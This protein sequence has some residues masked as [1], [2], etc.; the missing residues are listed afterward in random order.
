[1]KIIN[2]ETY[3]AYREEL[4]QKQ[5]N[6]RSSKKKTNQSRKSRSNNRQKKPRSSSIDDNKDSELEK[7]IELPIKEVDEYEEEIRSVNNR[8]N[9]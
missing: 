1:L 4:A 5:A 9:D 2:I 7:D 3:T 8:I 6:K